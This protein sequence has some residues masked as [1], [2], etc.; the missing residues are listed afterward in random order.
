MKKRKILKKEAEA[1]KD[2]LIN[3]KEDLIVQINDI[4][5]D[6][7]MK[8]QKE[9]SGD[10]SGYSLH[11]ADAATDSY[12]RDFNL[13]IVSSDRKVLLEV[14]E[15]LKRVEDGTY[16][17]CLCCGKDI[18]KTRLKAIPYAK[19]CRTCQ[20]KMEESEERI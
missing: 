1:Y 12:E 14:E 2:T 15:A 17:Q 9:I 13:G 20:I 16:G 4:S 11:P 19:F 8:S 18:T 10:V 5:H 7:L 3:L 6:T